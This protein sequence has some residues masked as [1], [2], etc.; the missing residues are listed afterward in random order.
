MKPNL[1][2]ECGVFGI[3]GHSHADILTYYAL[4]ALQHRGQEAAG[5][6]TVDECE[7]DIDVLRGQ[8]LVSEIFNESEIKQL[9]GRS[10]VGHVR[11]ST[12]GDS[13]LLNSQP[14][15]VRLKSTSLALAHNGNLINAGVL[16]DNLEEAGSIFQ[17]TSDT[18]VIAHLAARNPEKNIEDSLIQT[19]R[20]IKGGYALVIL[21]PEGM[22]AARDPHGI[23]PLCLGTLDGAPV[24]ASETC[25]LDT[26]GAEYV[27]D[28]RPGEFLVM[29]SKGRDSKRIADADSRALCI[30]EYIYFSRPD[31]NLA[32]QNVHRVR[33]KLGEY[34]AMDHP[35][36]ADVASGVPDSSISA[37]SG[38]AEEAEIPYEMGLVR[39]RYIGRTFIKPEDELR[40][41]GVKLKL[42]PLT[43][44]LK[45]RRVVLVDDSIVRGTTSRTLIKLLR[46]V[47]AKEVHMRISSPPYRYPCYYG[48][49]TSSTGELIAAN[50]S[51]KEIEKIIEAD[52]LAYLSKERVAEAAG[53][54]TE[55][56]CTACFSGDY[57]VEN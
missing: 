50:R 15:R 14:L 56:F 10:A 32:G 55:S 44:V 49:D 13:T 3:W 8:G 22:Y 23:R 6:A 28:I 31:S 12:T 24:V 1:R 39:N 19:L 54:T 41:V 29:D 16:R 17:T 34:L 9:N 36:D 25:A 46:E 27:R 37:A 40:Q 51:V 20:K 21:T 42:N 7:K 45:D 35:A 47:G 38:Y 5:I 48:I 11:Y 18:E 33:K 4:Y 30:F 43:K 52:S 57:P 2:E 26:V 53:A